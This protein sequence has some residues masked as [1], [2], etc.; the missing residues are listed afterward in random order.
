ML[1][2]L[3]FHYDSSKIY[4]IPWKMNRKYWPSIPKSLLYVLLLVWN[5]QVLNIQLYIMHVSQLYVLCI[6]LSLSDGIIWCIFCVSKKHVITCTAII[7]SHL[8]A[9]DLASEHCDW[10]MNMLPALHTVNAL[11]YCVKTNLYQIH[12]LYV[13]V[14]YV[15]I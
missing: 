1:Q 10:C 6:S 13:S 15:K 3:K 12:R 14:L 8:A 5:Y 2:Q 9:R 7:T 4:I 11:N